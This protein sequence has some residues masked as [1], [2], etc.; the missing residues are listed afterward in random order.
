M[1]Q[2]F[3]CIHIHSLEIQLSSGSCID[4]NFSVFAVASTWVAALSSSRANPPGTA[5][6]KNYVQQTKRIFNAIPAHVDILPYI[7][8]V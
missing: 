2:K 6:K 8:S 3:L 4:T 5:S 7:A 1:S